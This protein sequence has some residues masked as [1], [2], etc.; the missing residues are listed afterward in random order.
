MAITVNST[1]SSAN[2]NNAATVTWEHTTHA[3]DT[4]LIV[5][6]STFD[7]TEADR[8]VT[9]VTFNGVEDFT[10]PTFTHVYDDAAEHRTEIWYLPNP[11]ASTT[12]N[13]VV[14]L[15]DACTDVCAGA[16]GASGVN[17]GSPEDTSTT[18]NGA[19]GDPT[20]TLGAAA[21]N[22]LIVAGLIIAENAAAKLTCDQNQIYIT[23]MGND[24]GG[25][26][27]VR[28]DVGTTLS[29]TYTE[30]D[31]NWGMVACSFAKAPAQEVEDAVIRFT[32]VRIPRHP[33]Q[34]NTLMV[35]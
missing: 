29:W 19:A 16:I 30:D 20:V 15:T 12:A 11:S 7:L 28:Q 21:A 26:S 34:Y 6:V 31:Q 4:F 17:T 3:D 8:P 14:T 23:D 33:A 32:D 2:N 35:Y 27:Y 9:G 24:H 22:S 10:D 25:G 5:V 1:S 18:A 13:I